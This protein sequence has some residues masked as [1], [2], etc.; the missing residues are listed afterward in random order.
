LKAIYKKG[1][2]LVGLRMQHRHTNN[3]HKTFL[4]EIIVSTWQHQ[5][6]CHLPELFLLGNMKEK[7]LL[8]ERLLLV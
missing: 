5:P 7:A 2:V 1:S 4:E 6:K 8:W 3:Y